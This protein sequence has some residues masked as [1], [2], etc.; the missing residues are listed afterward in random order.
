[1]INRLNVL[2]AE[3]HVDVCVCVTKLVLEILV[4]VLQ[5]VIHIDVLLV[6]VLLLTDHP[7][8]TFVD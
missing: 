5:Q 6:R 4:R 3:E 2:V 7:A 1:M 8:H